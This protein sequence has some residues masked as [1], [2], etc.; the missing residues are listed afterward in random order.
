M[1]KTVLMAGLN[2]QYP[3]ML[4][5]TS[6]YLEVV[7]SQPTCLC[8]IKPSEVLFKDVFLDEEIEQIAASHVVQYLW[9]H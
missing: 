4:G 8:D 3:L 1:N 5:R 7:N 9:M 6:A 2:C